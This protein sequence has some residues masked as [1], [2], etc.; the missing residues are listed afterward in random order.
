MRQRCWW[1]CLGAND[2]AEKKLCSTKQGFHR[3]QC[4]PSTQSHESFDFNGNGITAQG[5]I[6]VQKLLLPATSAPSMP[7]VFLT[8][9]R[10]HKWNVSICSVPRHPPHLSFRICKR[11][12]WIF[13]AEP[14]QGKGKTLPSFLKAGFVE[15]MRIIATGVTLCPQAAYSVAVDVFFHYLFIFY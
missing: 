12:G 3:R 4:S 7:L 8:N 13:R 2:A 15:W 10:L 5:V 1:G 11:G 9:H 14:A 6:L